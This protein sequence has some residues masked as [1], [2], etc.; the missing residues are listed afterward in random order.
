[1]LH[2]SNGSVVTLSGTGAAA[3]TDGDSAS[4]AFNA[5]LS[6]AYD[7]DGGGAVLVADSENH[8]VRRVYANGTAE[9]VAGSGSY[10]FLDGAVGSAK[11]KR[12]AGGPMFW[13][14]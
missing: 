11:F 4:A 12:P 7:S 1:M 2:L 6:I 5:P 9:T 8:V 14:K 10:G 3:L 13:L